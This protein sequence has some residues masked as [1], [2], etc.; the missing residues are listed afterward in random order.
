MMKNLNFFATSDKSIE[1]DKTLGAKFPSFTGLSY[2][3]END[4]CAMQ[5]HSLLEGQTRL[6]HVASEKMQSDFPIFK[7]EKNASKR[8]DVKM[9]NTHTILPLLRRGL[10]GG[11]LFFLLLFSNLSYGQVNWSGTQTL[12]DGQVINYDINLT[13]HVSIHV[14]SGSAT[15]SGVIRS[16][17]YYSVTKSGAGTLYLTGNNAYIAPTI[18]SEGTLSLGNNTTTGHVMNNIA[19]NANLIFNHSND[20]EFV[21]VISGSG[22]VTKLGNSRLWLTGNNTYTGTTTIS[23]GVLYI[24]RNTTT[25]DIVGNIV[26]NGEL[27]F[28]RSNAYTYSGYISGTGSVYQWS[29][30]STLTLNGIN[31]YTGITYTDGPLALGPNGT[32]ASSSSV[33]LRDYSTASFNIS[34]GNKTIK[35]L[36]GVNASSRVILGSSTLTIGTSGQE[37]GSGTFAG[38]IS[39]TG[40]I[41]KT[42][43]DILILTGNNTYTGT[44]N[45][46]Q[47]LL[48]VGY[49]ANTGSIAGN[50]VNNSVLSIARSNAYTYPG[51]ISGSGRVLIERGPITFNTVHTYTGRTDVTFD[52]TLILGADARIENSSLISLGNTKLNVSAGN[53]KIKHLNSDN[54]NA[55]I[56]LGSSTLTIGTS[57]QTDG[58]GSFSGIFSGTGSVTKTGAANLTLSGQ[59]TATGALTVQ[60]GKL[61][62]ASRWQGNFIKDNNTELEIQGLVNIG[63]TATLQGGNIY[64]N[65]KTDPPAKLVVAG[66]MNPSG[67]NTLHI[68]C[69]SLANHAIFQASSGITA[70]PFKLNIPGSLEATGTQLLLTAAATSIEQL[71]IR[72]SEL[73]IYPNPTTGQLRITNYELRDGVNI[74]IFDTTGRSVGANLRIRPDGTINISHLPAGVYFLRVGNKSVRVV[75]N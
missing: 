13:G 15:I 52:A 18:I 35:A 8:E 44:T 30:S 72:N 43:S 3:P 69:N 64:M 50:I 11:V 33:T 40:G 70:S 12:V 42:G 21:S 22:T 7:W 46:E 6:Q 45:I 1:S 19:N 55:E 36:N 62:L 49:G 53:K 61:T 32:I 28:Y 20:Y 63:G 38:V 54:P 59:N 31:T 68:T 37:D 57:G 34:A 39:G 73:V 58:G 14:P 4:Y 65:L 2:V 27:L 9:Q 51:V 23:A 26:N 75:K 74:E 17:S 10:G 25:G 47:G 24:G 66:V 48:Y 41:T 5:G 29:E 67:V 60:Q 56:I 71:G 16:F